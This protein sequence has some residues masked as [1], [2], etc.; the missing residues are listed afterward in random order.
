[1]RA[2]YLVLAALAA[3]ACGGSAPRPAA[4]A[5]ATT[6]AIARAEASERARN[7][8]EARARYQ[9][10]ERDAPDDTSRAFA[11]RKR[12][13]ALMFWGEYE[14]AATALETVV[15]LAPADASAWHDLGILRHRAGDAA[16]AERALREAVAHAPKDA[17]PR[18][19]LAAVLVNQHRYGDALAEYEHILDLDIPERTRDAVHEGIA[20][21]RAEMARDGR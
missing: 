2:A 9:A 5:P 1:M 12:A 17:R 13:S 14:A 10:A 19:A 16:G 7:Y 15:A 4:V 6:Q 8:D 3:A 21:L 18:I 20:L 11:A